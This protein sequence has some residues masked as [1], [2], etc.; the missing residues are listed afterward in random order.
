MRDIVIY[1]NGERGFRTLERVVGGGHGVLAAVLP[2]KL[3]CSDTA[4]RATATGV[5]VWHAADVNDGAFVERLRSG[6]PKLGLI[7]GFST[8]FKAPLIGTPE[9]GTINLHAGRLPQYRGGS[10][11][12]WQIIN[13]EKTAGIS[14]IRIDEGIDTGPVLAEDEFP[15]DSTDTIAQIH[16]KANRRFPELVVQV[17][18]GLDKGTL[19][20][21]PQDEA[22]AHYWR[23]RKPADGRIDWREM[24]AR[25]VHDLVRAVT[26]PYPGAF[27]EW[28]GKQVRVFATE[29]AENG[30]DGEPGSVSRSAGGDIAV[31][32]SEGAVLFTDFDI[33]GDAGA[34]LP[35]GARLGSDGP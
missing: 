33:D 10:P 22:Q 13:G 6:K 24:T 17:L 31:A 23:Q 35:A 14:V 25:Q 1:F 7:A 12:N 11:L 34:D 5:E 32:C 8:I 29:L 28:D 21:T 9:L 26:R 19:T 15:I 18:E 27:T 30:F 3:E 16:E 4:R 2:E 20:E